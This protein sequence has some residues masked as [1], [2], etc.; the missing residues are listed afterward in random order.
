MKPVLNKTLKTQKTVIQKKKLQKNFYNLI[1]V[2]S[3]T[4]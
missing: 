3:Q 2:K 4:F 1:T